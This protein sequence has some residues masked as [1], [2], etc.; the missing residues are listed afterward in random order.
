VKKLTV[1]L[2][3][4]TGLVGKEVLGL[5]VGDARVSN[6]VLLNRDPD[7]ALLEAMEFE[8][9]NNILSESF[10]LLERAQ[11][12]GNIFDSS[13]SSPELVTSSNNDLA[14]TKRSIEMLASES[15]LRTNN[16]ILNEQ[17]SNYLNSAKSATQSIWVICC[18]GTTIK[19]AASKEAFEEVDR[20]LVV[21]LGRWAKAVG[22]VGMTVVSSLGAD[23]GSMFFYS[24]VKGH[25]EKDLES[26]GLNHLHFIRP[27]LLLGER[28]ESRPAEYLSQ[29]ILRRLPFL[30]VGKLKAYAPIA[31]QD[32]AQQVVQTLLVR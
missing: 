29:K 8:P 31:A 24:R 13:N 14:E 6:I 32:V 18:I 20:H 23:P 11:F 27:S 25:M 15:P 2:A 19:K 30:F 16:E 4:S 17:F 3:G 1:V 22:A 9:K 26:L 10:D 28:K 5:L 21:K 7:R 12:G